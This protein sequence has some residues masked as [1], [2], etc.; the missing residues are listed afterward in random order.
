MLTEKNNLRKQV[1][2][3]RKNL[4]H[5]EVTEKS[6]CVLNQLHTAYTFNHTTVAMCYVPFDNEVDTRPFLDAMIAAHG[7]VILPMI[8][9]NDIVPR[10]VSSLQHCSNNCFGIPEPTQHRSSSIDV[11]MLSVIIVPGVAFDVQCNR[12][13]SGKGFYDRFLSNI[14]RMRSHAPRT[15]GIAYDFQIIENVYTEP[16]HDVPMDMVVTE[17]TIYQRG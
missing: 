9:G 14:H 15:I 17:Q 6:L 16:H 5:K 7:V 4:T 13:G 8:V 3:L 1:R 12:L 11:G 10:A 2:A